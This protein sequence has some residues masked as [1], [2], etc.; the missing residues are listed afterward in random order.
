MSKQNPIQEKSFSFALTTVRI[1]K[2]LIKQNE[3]ILSKQLMRSGTSVGANIREAQN[4][5]SKKDFIHK[6]SISQKECDES[7]YWIELLFHS[8]MITKQNY[9][10]LHSQAS[11]LLKMLKSIIITS[12]KNL[13]INNS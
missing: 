8:K 9:Y 4:A 7:I 10:L 2:E 12:K 5:E 6:L 3:Y 13:A 1:C 11:V